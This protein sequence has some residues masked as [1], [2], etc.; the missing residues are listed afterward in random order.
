MARPRGAKERATAVV[1]LLNLVWGAASALGP[2]AAGAVLQLAGFS[3]AFALLAALTGSVGIALVAAESSRFPH[4]T[5]T[6]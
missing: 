3:T 5:R 2:V 6:R 1:G 4:V